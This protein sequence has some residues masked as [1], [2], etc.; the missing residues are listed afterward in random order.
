VAAA[1]ALVA[2][3]II[4]I[5][6]RARSLSLSLARLPINFQFAA[7][8]VLVLFYAEDVRKRKGELYEQRRLSRTTAH[9]IYYGVNLLFSVVSIGTS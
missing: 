7:F 5:L 8:S 6:T 3:A 1:V 9:R 2:L 4:Q